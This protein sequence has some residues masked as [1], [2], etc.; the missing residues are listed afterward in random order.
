MRLTRP[1]DHVFDQATKLKVLRVMSAT[2][3]EMPVRKIAASAGVSHVQAGAALSALGREGVVSRRAAG[4]ALLYRLEPENALVAR[5]LVPL[6]EEER[7]LRNRLGDEL[8]RG[9]EGVARGV[10]IYGSV[11][12]ETE[13]PGS[14]LDLLV[15]PAAR[16]GRGIEDRLQRLASDVRK[17]YGF[18]L[19]PLVLSLPEVKARYRRRDPLIVAIV[20]RSEPVIGSPLSEE[21]AVGR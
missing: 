14:D 12:A 21:I 5:M 20:E 13:G 1:L 15:I 10:Y 3:A 2:M 4:R 7:H 9:L 6:F 16:G 19:A 18:E 11:G 8:A 17:D